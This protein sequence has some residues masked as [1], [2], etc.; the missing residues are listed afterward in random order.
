MPNELVSIIDRTY[1]AFELPFSVGE[2]KSSIPYTIGVH[3]GD[4]LA[5]I[6]FNLIFKLPSNLSPPPGKVIT[7]SPHQN[8]DGF[9]KKKVD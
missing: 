1:Q 7:P 3:Q 2:V 8:F 4:N 5:P 9:L 6:L